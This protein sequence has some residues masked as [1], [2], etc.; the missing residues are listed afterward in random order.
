LPGKNIRDF[1]GKPAIA[2]A[3]GAAFRSEIFDRVIVSTDCAEIA[4]IGISFGAEVPFLRPAGLSGDEC[5]TLPVLQH[6]LEFLQGKGDPIAFACCIYPTAVLLAAHHLRESFR[7]LLAAPTCNYCFSVCAYEHPVQ[8]A[9]RIDDSGIVAP[10]SSEYSNTRTQDLLPLYY[11]AGQFYWGVATAM[12]AG[13]PIFSSAALP[14]ILSKNEFVDVN[15]LED[16]E[17]AEA[18]A[19]AL[20]QT[21]ARFDSRSCAEAPFLALAR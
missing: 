8:R 18:L 1:L 12:R 7:R 3:I 11:D 9:L 15:E 17:R 14:Y 5:G 10:V 21:S 19:K 13:K 16:W 20:S 4:S 6:V 2:H